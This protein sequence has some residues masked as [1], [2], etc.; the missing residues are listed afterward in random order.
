MAWMARWITLAA[1]LLLG[2][3]AV[4]PPTGPTVMALPAKG[5]DLAQFQ[6]DDLSCRQ[7]AWNQIGGT[8]PADAANQSLANSA[9]LGTVLG[10]AAGAAIGAATGN[11]AAGAAIGA[12]S[13][14]LL[15]SAAGADAAGYSAAA[16][17]RRYDIG[18][19]QCMSAL[20]NIAPVV[21][22]GPAYGYYP[23]PYAYAYPYPYP[24]A[25]PWYWG[26][27]V[28]VGASFV[29]FGGH[30]HHGGHHGHGGGPH[31]AMAHR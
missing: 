1:G 23:A 14:L 18:Y 8:A 28:G 10:A 20:G 30:G 16:L 11:P 29:F 5:K 26:A 4:A 24:Y 13:G 6:N 19:V 17:Q 25:Y 15:G 7:Y 2:A 3:C 9:T 22:S 12:G 31:G 27:P 21:A